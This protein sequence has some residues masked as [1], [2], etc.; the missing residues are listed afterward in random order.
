MLP[1][2]REGT[3]GEVTVHWV[4]SG[5]GPNRDHVIESDVSP[6]SGIVAMTSGLGDIVMAAVIPLF[7]VPSFLNIYD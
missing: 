4:L 7:N 2:Q 3:N 6:M 5:S 1:L